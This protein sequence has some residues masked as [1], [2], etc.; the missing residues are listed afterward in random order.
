MVKQ[1]KYDLVIDCGIPYELKKLSEKKLMIELKKLGKKS[2]KAPY[3]DINIYRGK[4]DVSNNMFK[5][6]HKM[7]KKQWEMR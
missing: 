3:C 7:T 5:K 1:K 2:K 6:F 4:R